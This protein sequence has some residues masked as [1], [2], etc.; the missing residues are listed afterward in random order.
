MS[1]NFVDYA[2]IVHMEMFSCIISASVCEL[3]ARNLLHDLHIQISRL[4][5]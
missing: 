1:Y 2:M 3:F 5:T 4:A